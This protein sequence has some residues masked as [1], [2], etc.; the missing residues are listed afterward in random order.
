[1]SAFTPRTAKNSNFARVVKNLG[2]FAQFVFRRTHDWRRILNPQCKRRGR[3]FAKSHV[4]GNDHHGHTPLAEGSAHRDA[5]NSWHLICL[6]NQFA[7]VAAILEQLFWTRLLK[8]A[9]AHF[10]AWDLCRNGKHGNPAPV[11][12]VEAVNEVKIPRATTACADGKI[13]G[14]GSLGA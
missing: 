13:A 6:R 11:A 1:M 2:S 9:A 12:I 7:V 4:G 8:I 5:E 10:I 14:E 3:T